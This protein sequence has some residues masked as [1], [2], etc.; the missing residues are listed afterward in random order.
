MS[1]FT[2]IASVRPIQEFHQEGN[3]VPFKSGEYFK[4]YLPFTLPYV[5]K[6]GYLKDELEIITF[7][8]ET[9][10]IGDVIEIY[11]YEEGRHCRVLS[12]NYPEEARRVNLLK[13]TYKD[14]YGEYHLNEKKWKEELSRRTIASKRS[15][16]TFVKY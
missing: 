5:Y 9:M 12:F 1:S 11:I 16:T 7:L 14:Q 10:E 4:P 6:I 15:I 2:F 13:K 3:D 8:D